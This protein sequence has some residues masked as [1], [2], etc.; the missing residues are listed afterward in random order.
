M[1]EQAPSKERFQQIEAYETA[2]FR[3]RCC[4]HDPEH[5]VVTGGQQWSSWSMN[6]T[7][8]KKLYDWLG[9]ALGVSTPEP[10]ADPDE[11]AADLRAVEAFI[12]RAQ[13]MRHSLLIAAAM[14]DQAPPSG[15]ANAIQALQIVERLLIEVG[16]QP[17]S[18]TRHNLSIALSNLRSATQPPSPALRDVVQILEDGKE[19]ASVFHLRGAIIQALM[20]LHEQHPDAWPTATKETGL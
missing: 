1:N 17:D 16:Y 2:E 10:L 20:K 6:R 4:K 5:V 7:V 3:I 18:S 11:I 9:R 19:L 13:G 8:A 12:E 15:V 14:V